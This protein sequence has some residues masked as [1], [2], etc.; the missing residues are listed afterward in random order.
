M[1]GRV[2]EVGAPGKSVVIAGGKRGVLLGGKSAI[3]KE[4]G[5]CPVCCLEFSVR[6]SFT[7]DGLIDGGQNGSYRAYENPGDVPA[8]PWTVFNNGL[9]IRLEWED[10]YNCQNH[11][12][13]TQY[14]TAT[15]EIMVPETM[16]LTLN[17]YG[18]DETDEEKGTLS[19]GVDG[20]AVG[21]AH[22]PG[23]G[24][25]C[26]PMA[27]I[28]SN[29]PPPQQ[30]TLTTGL[31]ILHIDATTWDELYHFGAWYQIELTFNPPP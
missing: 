24:L 30:V 20:N 19:I 5:I 25:G 29:P 3:Y 2:G 17:W 28:V 7:D 1:S 31:H 18:M 14:A 4:Q 8:S 26:A 9:G 6:W 22:S 12:P 16:V 21:G 10:D 27:P 13:Y 15:A 23:G 11:N